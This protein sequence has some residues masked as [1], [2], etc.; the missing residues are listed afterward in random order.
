MVKRVSMWSI[1]SDLASTYG[2]DG[3]PDYVDVE[4][5]LLF[6]TMYN[7][8]VNSEEAAKI[9]GVS[10]KSLKMLNSKAEKYGYEDID[11][12]YNDYL[13]W[14]FDLKG[15]DIL[16]PNLFIDSLD[17]SKC[18]DLLA[19]AIDM[20]SLEELHGITGK[21]LTKYYFIYMDYIPLLFSYIIVDELPNSINQIAKLD[22]SLVSKDIAT[23]LSYDISSAYE[24]YTGNKDIS[25]YKLPESDEITLEVLENLIELLY[26][27]DYDDLIV[28]LKKD[29]R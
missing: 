22:K 23:K 10:S 2:M 25:W 26:K 19:K 29:V 8:K 9:L 16:R 5:A 12:V 6:I 28:K 17:K 18:Y 4:L 7:R 13:G 1:V 24:Y 20:S 21:D 15:K 11:E 14:S 3:M 27:T